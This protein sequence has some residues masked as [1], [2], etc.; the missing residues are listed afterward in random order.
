VKVDARLH[1]PLALLALTLLAFM[2]FEA[3]REERRRA[4]ETLGY[5]L[6]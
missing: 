3:Y 2:A 1:L 5:H 6:W 4:I